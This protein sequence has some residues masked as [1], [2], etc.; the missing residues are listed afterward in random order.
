MITIS[1]FFVTWWLWPYEINEQ[2]GTSPSIVMQ[3]TLRRTWYGSLEHAAKAR[4]ID[5]DTGRTIAE[6]DVVGQE[7]GTIVD[8]WMG[9]RQYRYWNLDGTLLCWD[10]WFQFVGTTD[11]FHTKE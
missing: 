4:L 3:T 10:D 1:A 8:W 6:A 2:W 11:H 9:D 7:V 5:S